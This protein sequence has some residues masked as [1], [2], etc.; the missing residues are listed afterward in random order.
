M[1]GRGHY[2]QGGGRVGHGSYC[3]IVTPETFP[4]E[5]LPPETW[6]RLS[7]RFDMGQIVI[8]FL[9]ITFSFLRENFRRRARKHRSNCQ[10]VTRNKSLAYNIDAIPIYKYTTY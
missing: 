2:H 3:Q 9:L 5:T 1:P 4:P 6:V 8:F 7:R 10:I